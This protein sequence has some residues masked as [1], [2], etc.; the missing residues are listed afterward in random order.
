VG[1]S[2][3]ENLAWRWVEAQ[4]KMSLAQPGGLG[5]DWLVTQSGLLPAD[6][7]GG[8]GGGGSNLSAT[9]HV[10][11]SFLCKGYLF[12]RLG[13]S[14]DPRTAAAA[15]AG[16]V[17]APPPPAPPPR[18]RHNASDGT[19]HSVGVSP[20]RGSGWWCEWSTAFGT[21]LGRA[22]PSDDDDDDTFDGGGG[23][24]GGGGSG[25]GGDDRYP[26]EELWAVLPKRHWLSLAVATIVDHQQQQQLPGGSKCGD[27][28]MQSSPS[29]VI[30]EG[31]PE[32]GIEPLPTLSAR[33]LAVA[34]ARHFEP[35]EP[36]VSILEPVH[37]D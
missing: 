1:P 16:H 6:G 28:S 24:T 30:I 5:W 4:R 12:E 15:A 22:P 18:R 11:S 9:P 17:N 26:P 21:S 7:G 36:G 2:L 14:L 10:L 34:L 31:I 13:P 35:G 37:I 33:S 23:G 25:S 3:H 32:L 8:G 20:E 27:A 29:A 19:V